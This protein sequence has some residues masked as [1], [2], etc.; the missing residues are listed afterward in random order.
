[1]YGAANLDWVFLDSAHSPF[2]SDVLH[3]LIR[4]YRVT[5]ITTVV[6]V[7]GFQ[8]V[9]AV[10]SRFWRRG[11]QRGVPPL[12]RNHGSRSRRSA[13]AEAS[14]KF[15]MPVMLRFEKLRGSDV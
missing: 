1:M 2:S 13:G 4:A 3:D 11:G 7:C 9:A 8:F 12:H 10:P 5:D 15:E 6:R 14:A